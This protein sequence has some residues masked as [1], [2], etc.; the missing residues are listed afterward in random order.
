VREYA[1]SLIDRLL[2]GRLRICSSK[3]KTRLA[4]GCSASEQDL[5][6]SPLASLLPLQDART[7]RACYFASGPTCCPCSIMTRDA[8]LYRLEVVDLLRISLDR[9]ANRAPTRALPGSLR[10]LPAYCS[11]FPTA[12]RRSQIFNVQAIDPSALCLGHSTRD[13][14]PSRPPTI[15][16]RL[17]R[18][19]LACWVLLP[20]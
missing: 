19:T 20:S 3:C 9:G 14:F 10:H 17:P 15:A 6:R 5:F 1:A 18:T 12:S 4:S 11:R 16:Q 2:F 8:L 13:C 7:L